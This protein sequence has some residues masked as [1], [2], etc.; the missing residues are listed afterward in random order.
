MAIVFDLKNWGTPEVSE[1][2]DDFL[3]KIDIN[4]VHEVRKNDNPYHILVQN[5]FSN[6]EYI[7]VGLHGALER[8]KIVPPAFFFRGGGSEIGC[9]FNF[10]FGSQY[11]YFREVT[12]RLVFR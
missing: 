9:W 12:F 6:N 11:K 3:R 8:S 7:L 4:G 1:N 10:N 5:I 2:F